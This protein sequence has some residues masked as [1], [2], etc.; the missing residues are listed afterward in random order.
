MLSWPKKGRSTLATSSSFLSRLTSSLR[1][2]EPSSGRLDVPLA[3]M[4]AADLACSLVVFLVVSS[5]STSATGCDV[6]DRYTA[7]MVSV[8]KSHSCN[9]KSSGATQTRRS[10]SLQA[11]ST[12]GLLYVSAGALSSGAT[13]D[14]MA[15]W[16][17]ALMT[18]H[19]AARWMAPVLSTRART[20]MYTSARVVDDGEDV[21]VA[22]RS[23]TSFS[24][25]VG[26][27]VTKLSLADASTSMAMRRRLSC[28]LR[29]A[30]RR[31]DVAPTPITMPAVVG[32]V[33]RVS[34]SG[35][36]S[37]SLMV[38]CLSRGSQSLLI[39][40]WLEP[41]NLASLKASVTSFFQAF[42]LLGSL[43]SSWS[44]TSELLEIESGN[45]LA[46]SAGPI[47]LVDIVAAACSTRS[48]STNTL[49]RLGTMAAS[50]PTTSSALSEGV[51]F[52]GVRRDN[53]LPLG[54]S[55]W[56]DEVSAKLRGR[57]VKRAVK[58]RRN[59]S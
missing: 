4:C 54:F 59:K 23:S 41:K 16:S 20:T 13:T 30:S 9:W 29:S 53:S 3:A 58:S 28:V 50:I 25:M 33:M 1:P 56:E 17:A 19:R 2:P 26:R 46:R 43:E 34:I 12:D 40:D 45:V 21:A 24:R 57:V 55:D 38:H 22:P 52:C 39:W 47:T 7:S 35:I 14:E 18:G 51:L 37:L 27:S 32:G 48:V 11:C 49:G 6:D 10:S 5:S 31:A 15:A 8:T 44:S 36:L 42:W